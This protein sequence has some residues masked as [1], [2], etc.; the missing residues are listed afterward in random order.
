MWMM[1]RKST[2]PHLPRMVPSDTCCPNKTHLSNSE[3]PSLETSQSPWT[4]HSTAVMTCSNWSDVFPVNCVI[5]ACL[6]WTHFKC[7]REAEKTFRWNPPVK[8]KQSL[9]LA[10]SWGLA[11]RARGAAGAQNPDSTG[12]TDLSGQGPNPA[13]PAMATAVPLSDAFLSGPT[14]PKSECLKQFQK[15]I[16]IKIMKYHFHL[17]M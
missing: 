1:A 8:G 13:L 15:K 5:I 17:S 6:N 10:G 2:S 3:V 9:V 12:D 7:T 11:S 4:W 14:S 16:I